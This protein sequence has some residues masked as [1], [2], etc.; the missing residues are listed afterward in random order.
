MNFWDQRYSEDGFAYGTLANDFL[1]DQTHHIPQ[2]RVLCLAEGEGRNAVHLA[3]LGY[4]VTAVDQSAVG[5]NKARQL[6]ELHRVSINTVVAD[7]ADYPIISSDWDG[8]VSISAHLPPAIR[9]RVHQQVVN[10][11]KPG[12]ILILEAYTPRH[13]DIGGIGGPARDNKD[14]FMSLTILRKELK[15]LIFDLARE[16]DR[17]V[18]E[19]RYHKGMGSVVQLVARK[20]Q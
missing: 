5:M 10:G 1:A 13:L 15:G 4:Q 6:A 3:K 16:V 9:Q 19:G 14:M 7:L 20:P 2:G 8:I 18:N 12:G 17:E 11:L